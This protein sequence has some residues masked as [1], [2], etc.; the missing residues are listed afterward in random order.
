MLLVAAITFR[1]S[2]GV[3]MMEMTKEGTLNIGQSNGTGNVSG[4]VTS[5]GSFGRVRSDIFS[6]SFH[7]QIGEICVHTINPSNNLDNTS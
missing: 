5:T 7:G 4:S 6:G 2:G 1:G 3:D